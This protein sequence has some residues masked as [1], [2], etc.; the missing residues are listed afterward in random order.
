LPTALGNNEAGRFVSSFI[1]ESLPG[2]E[3]TAARYERKRS[4]LKTKTMGHKHWTKRSRETG[5]F[6]NRK[7]AGNSSRFAGKRATDRVPGSNPFLD[8]TSMM[9]PVITFGKSELRSTPEQYRALA[10]EC[11]K[12]ADSAKT[13]EQR[14]IL[15]DMATHWAEAAARLD[16][17]HA[18]IGLFGELMSKA[19]ANPRA[20]SKVLA[21]HGSGL[22]KHTNGSGQPKQP[23]AASHAKYHQQREH[24]AREWR[25]LAWQA[26]LDGEH[27]EE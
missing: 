27:E 22:S 16:H 25:N 17:Q 2:D 24:L 19:K 5:T 15:L 18:L 11:M 13:I 12:W 6:T 1:Q 23:E 9:L 21:A 7:K 3:Q 10:R 8:Y 26:E 4:Q 20:V 14:E